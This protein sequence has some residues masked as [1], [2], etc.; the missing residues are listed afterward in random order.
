MSK[1][2]L[3]HDQKRKAK[4]AQRARKHPAPAH[5]LAYT[6]NRFKTPELTPLFA[7]TETAIVQADTIAVQTLTDRQVR[8]ALETLVEAIRDGKLELIDS[9]AELSF[10]QGQEVEL[11]TTMMRSSWAD[12]TG[13]SL[14]AGPETMIGVL[15]TILGSI[16]TWTTPAPTSRGYISYVTAFLR[17]MGVR[18]TTQTGGTASE[19][20]EDPFLEVGEAWV[21][22]RD[23]IAR[24]EFLRQAKEMIGSGQGE[25]VAEV[26]QMLIAQIG[27][28]PVT[29]ELMF[30]S[31]AAQRGEVRGLPE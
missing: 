16:E 22:D 6:G 17:K 11:I 19:P 20:P 15:R 24:R 5:S 1:K 2:R 9:Q 3:S 14:P 13:A 26:A 10:R 12:G 28:G 30:V 29:Q 8:T 18:V 4:L 23:A 25:R 21:L 7:M 27:D 31:V